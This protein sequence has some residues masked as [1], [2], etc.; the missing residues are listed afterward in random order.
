[1]P[2]ND[3]ILSLIM[4]LAVFSL[5]AIINEV[6]RAQSA[7]KPSLQESQPSIIPKQEAKSL[8]REFFSL[9]LEQPLEFSNLPFDIEQE[10]FLFPQFGGNKTIEE[11]QEEAP[12]F[13][14]F[15]GE[16][17]IGK[18]YEARR[19][20]LKAQ[21]NGVPSI[22]SSLE[23]DV[24]SPQDLVT[25]LKFEHLSYL[26]DTVKHLNKKGKTPYL[27]IDNAH[28]LINSQ[29]CASCGV[30]N[31]LFLSNNINIILIAND[32]NLPND[33]ASWEIFRKFALLL[34][35]ILFCLFINCFFFLKKKNH[36]IEKELRLV[37]IRKLQ[38]PSLSLWGNYSQKV[39]NTLIVNE[40]K[41][42]TQEQLSQCDEILDVNW[43]L[44]SDYLNQIESANNFSGKSNQIKYFKHEG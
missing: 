19:I 34:C 21:E 40:E 24:R 11:S 23:G 15:T 32:E 42:L 12:H 7:T 38:K 2:E 29:G 30:L 28:H 13:L 17:K 39:F 9:S 10:H 33:S 41:R 26:E 43:K 1:M 25:A 37:E 5:V 20:V 16:A 4:I 35:K 3:K 6:K 31:S 27:L 18:S 44:L 22:Y 8:E 14:L 36:S